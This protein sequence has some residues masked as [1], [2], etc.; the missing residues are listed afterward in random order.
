MIFTDYIFVLALIVLIGINLVVLRWR[1]LRECVLILASFAFFLSWG[2]EDVLLFLCVM[3]FGYIAAAAIDHTTGASRRYVLL[4]STVV[5]LGTLGFF[6]YSVFLVHSVAGNPFLLTVLQGHVWAALGLSFYTFHIISYTTDIHL[7]KYRPAPA[8][9]YVAYISFFPHL[10]AGPIVRG[11][12]LIPQFQ[13]PPPASKFDWIGGIYVFSL[14]F[15]L[16]AT[17]DVIGGATAHDWTAAAVRDYGVGDAWV[18]ALLFA[19]QIFCDFAGYSYLAIGMGR[20]LGVELPTNFNAPYLASSF[21]EFWT[22]WHITLS[23]WLRDYL[24]IFV[25]GGNRRGPVRTQAN[26]LATMLL[27]GLWHGA[28]WTF[29]AWGGVHG[30]ALIIE[31]WLG[32]ERHEET[33]R[34]VRALW[35]LVVQLVVLIAWVFFRSPSFSVAGTMLKTMA[36]G[37]PFTAQPGRLGALILIVPVVGYHLVRFAGERWRYRSP[38]LLGVVSLLLLVLGMSILT[39]PRTFIYYEF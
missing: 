8:L 3:T 19:C 18:A 27:G 34:A 28:N 30:A 5:L 14:G 11:P 39:R 12:Q 2:G 25:L 38:F 10:L 21:R 6:K 31:R 20:L 36:G 22:R 17:A 37:A 13:H 9:D 15:F 29:V 33:P 32:L 1:L 7:K 35:W 24:Y 26:T 23:A 16:K 4:A